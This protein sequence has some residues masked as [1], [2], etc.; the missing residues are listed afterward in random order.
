LKVSFM[1]RTIRQTLGRGQIEGGKLFLKILGMSID[2][3]GID[4]IIERVRY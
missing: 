2:R 3:T 4:C 1:Q